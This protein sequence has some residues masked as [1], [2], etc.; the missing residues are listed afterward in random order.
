MKKKDPTYRFGRG[1]SIGYIPAKNPT[2]PYNALVVKDGVPISAGCRATLKEAALTAVGAAYHYCT[3]DISRSQ[4][5]F[6]RNGLGGFTTKDLITY[7]PNTFH[8]GWYVRRQG[9]RYIGYTGHHTRINGK[10]KYKLTFVCTRMSKRIAI[11]K[12]IEAAKQ[13]D[14]YDAD[15]SVLWLTRNGYADLIPVAK[16][17]A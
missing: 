6:T 16:E 7:A 4:R 17:V 5:W 9:E 10:R 1:W 3:L 14:R 15:R 2:Y 11:E 12:T 13:T 8:K